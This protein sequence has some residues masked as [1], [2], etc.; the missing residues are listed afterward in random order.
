MSGAV[1]AVWGGASVLNN[2]GKGVWRTK[3]L[4]EPLLT[5]Q[6]RPS[7]LFQIQAPAV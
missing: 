2:L 4:A 7:G 6:V 3:T 5:L 1:R